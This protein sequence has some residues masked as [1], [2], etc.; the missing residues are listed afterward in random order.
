[1][2]QQARPTHSVI[3]I[4]C[5]KSLDLFH[6]FAGNVSNSTTFQVFCNDTKAEIG[7]ELLLMTNDLLHSVYQPINT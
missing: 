2:C 1:M 7:L 4:Y 3:F 6:T 5:G